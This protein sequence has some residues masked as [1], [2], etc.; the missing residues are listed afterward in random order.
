MIKPKIALLTQWYLP[1]NNAGGPVRSIFSLVELLKNDFEFYIITT[2]TDLN[3]E[4][5]YK[6]IQQNKWFIENGI[7]Y[8]YHNTENLRA[9]DI[10][11]N[12]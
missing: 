3:S 9:T 10:I 2:N 8:Y 7:N 5:P 1:G 12:I 11:K 4:T 6:N